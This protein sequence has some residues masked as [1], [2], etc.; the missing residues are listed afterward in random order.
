MPPPLVLDVGA[1]QKYNNNVIDT[2][3]QNP[4]NMIGFEEEP[5]FW[6]PFFFRGKRFQ[7]F[8]PQ[9][10]GTEINVKMVEG[11]AERMANPMMVQ[12]LQSADS[13]HV[14]HRDVNP[15]IIFGKKV[16]IR[17]I[18]FHFRRHSL[19]FGRNLKISPNFLNLSENGNGSFF[20]AAVK[21]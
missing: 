2:T 6:K 8:S 4:G 20:F 10:G 17:I 13:L 1:P 7:L 21:Y 9:S 16:I 5:C 19:I 18:K 3:A 11:G 15:Y 12:Y 14:D